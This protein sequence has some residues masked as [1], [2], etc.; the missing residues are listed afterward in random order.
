MTFQLL[1]KTKM[2]T[3]EEVSCFKSLRC[4]IYHANK[5]LNANNCA[6]IPGGSKYHSTCDN[7]GK[8][9]PYS[10]KDNPLIINL[11]AI[12]VKKHRYAVDKKN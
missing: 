6:N 7:I 1:I 5:Y 2:P 8:I 9:S 10:G 11:Q 12:A 3:N 4:C